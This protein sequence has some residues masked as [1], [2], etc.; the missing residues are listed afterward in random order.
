MKPFNIT[1]P[2]GPLLAERTDGGDRLTKLAERIREAHRQAEDQARNAVRL[3][4]EAGADL[5][6]AKREVEHGQW[7]AWVEANCHFSARA[8]RGYMQIAD[9]MQ[10]LPEADRQRVAE[11]PLREAFKAIAAPATDP[12]AAPRPAGPKWVRMR[13]KADMERFHEE[14]GDAASK[15]RLVAR[16]VGANALQRKD[17]ERARKALTSALEVLDQLAAAEVRDA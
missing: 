2:A 8:A 6:A 16:N 3:A 13:S 5:A 15:L 12:A 1:I 4:A 17:F 7:E 14:L 10:A 11:L 9:R